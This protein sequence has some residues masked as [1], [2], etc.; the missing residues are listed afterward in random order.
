MN[1]HVFVA[2]L[3]LISATAAIQSQA[4]D[5]DVRVTAGPVYMGVDIG[6]PPPPPLVEVVP[7]PRVGY[8]WA[9]GY[10]AWDGHRHVWVAGRWVSGRPG[11]VYVPAGWEQRGN[12]WHYEPEHWADHRHDDHHRGEG[13]D[14]RHHHDERHDH[15][16]R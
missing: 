10:W 14:D 11:Y 5:V 1:K 7:A 6:N 13:H 8:V 4:A 3:A 15:D 16:G 12:H 2:A 9:P